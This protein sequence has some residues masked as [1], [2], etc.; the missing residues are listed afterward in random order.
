VSGHACLTAPAVEVIRR[1]LGETTP[2]ELLSVNSSI[3]RT[4]ATLSDLEDDAFHA[5]IWS[6]LHFRTAMEDGYQIGHHTAAEVLTLI[7]ER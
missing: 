7:R 5:R 3:P 2:L 4:Y 1:M 6:G